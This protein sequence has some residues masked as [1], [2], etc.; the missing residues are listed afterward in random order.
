MAVAVVYVRDVVEQNSEPS[1]LRRSHFADG[2]VRYRWFWVGWASCG[3][4]WLI[5]WLCTCVGVDVSWKY[6]VAEVLCIRIYRCVM[7]KT[8]PLV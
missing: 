7:N 6:Q 5:V 4:V 8:N 3:L 1:S 2:R